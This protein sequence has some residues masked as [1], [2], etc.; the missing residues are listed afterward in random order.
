[1]PRGPRGE[2]RPAD[3]IGCA[4][5]VGKI[6]TGEVEEPLAP[7]RHERA[8]LGG[9]ARMA[10]LSEEARSEIGKR[11]AGARWNSKEARM[12]ELHSADLAVLYERKTREDGLLDAKFLLRPNEEA[13]TEETCGEILNFYR[14]VAQGATEAL[15]FGDLRWKEPE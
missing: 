9:Q 11:A 8:R 6:A 1:M 2:K 15:D 5:M 10:A 14:A 12:N 4:V 7:E 3:A 13:A